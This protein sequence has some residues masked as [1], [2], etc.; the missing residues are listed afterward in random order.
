[1]YHKISKNMPTL[2][3]TILEGVRS[4]LLKYP[5]TQD[6]LIIWAACCIAFF[7]LLRV[8]EFTTPTQSH[9]NPSSHLSLA[10]VALDSCT[11]PQVIRITLKQSKTDQLRQGTHLYLGKT[12]H[13]VCPVEAIILYLIA[14]G[15]RPG[16][17]LC[18]AH[19]KAL[20]RQME[21]SCLSQ[22]RLS[23]TTGHSKPL[24]ELDPNATTCKT[25]IRL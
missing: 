16:P 24:Q 14:R 25:S 3:F 23:L 20:G 19:L 5:C 12:G 7:G 2:T 9:S 21:K 6:D 17:L 15:N 13:H 8:S 1:M 11:S 18:Y 22:I 4:V 10:A